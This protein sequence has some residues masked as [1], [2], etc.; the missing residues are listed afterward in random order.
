MFMCDIR[1]S[2][3]VNMYEDAMGCK[4]MGV[5]RICGVWKRPDNICEDL[6]WESTV[7]IFVWLRGVTRHQKCCVKA[8]CDH[9]LVYCYVAFLADKPRQ[10]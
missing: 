6:V 1:C 9:V 5:L 3:S 2:G 7:G 10:Y 4:Q 8:M